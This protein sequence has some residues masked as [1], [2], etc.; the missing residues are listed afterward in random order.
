[1]EDIDLG[2]PDNVSVKRLRFGAQIASVPVRIWN[3]Q[4]LALASGS[5]KTIAAVSAVPVRI[6]PK[7]PLTIQ[8]GRRR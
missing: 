7:R 8:S 1:M 3:S 5:Q 4:P 6:R 2:Q